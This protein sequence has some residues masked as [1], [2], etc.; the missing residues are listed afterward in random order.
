VSNRLSEV[1]KVLTVFASIFGPLTVLT[2]LYGMNVTLPQFPGGEDAQF[3]WI[4]GLMALISGSL[5]LVFRRL[6]WL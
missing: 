3:W 6:K 1:M 5:L 2:S 4:A